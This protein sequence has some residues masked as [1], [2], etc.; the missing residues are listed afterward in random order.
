[1]CFESRNK[2]LPPPK[3]I[4]NSC[5]PVRAALPAARIEE[6]ASKVKSKVG[7][8]RVMDT[9]SGYLR[10]FATEESFLKNVKL[11]AR[12]YKY[13]S[14]TVKAIETGAKEYFAQQAR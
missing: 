3:P 6:I 13:G 2:P 5:A 1:M 9:L 10:S 7:R 4:I 14:Q 8:S 11:D 12:L